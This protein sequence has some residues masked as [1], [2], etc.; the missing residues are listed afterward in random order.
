MII[1]LV[2]LTVDRVLF[3]IQRQLFPYQYGGDGILH[4]ALRFV[5]RRCEDLK[6]LVVRPVAWE[7][8]ATG[9]AK[10]DTSKP[11]WKP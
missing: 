5:L 11:K 3:W 2:A 1:P 9:T 8:V 10:D 4:Q 7:P 6:L